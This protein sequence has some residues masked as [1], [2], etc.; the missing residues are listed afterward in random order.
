[1]LYCA[2]SHVSRWGNKKFRGNKKQHSLPHAHVRSEIKDL[3]QVRKERQ[4]KA[5]RMSYLKSKATKHKQQGSRNGRKGKG[6]K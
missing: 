1:M 2:G 4:K 3:E 6:K 5:N